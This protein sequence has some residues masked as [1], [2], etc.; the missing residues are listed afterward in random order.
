[1]S[2]PAAS[3]IFLPACD[4][5]RMLRDRQISATELL[6]LHL[7]RVRAVNPKINAIVALDEEHARADAKRAD[8]MATRGR[9]LGPL[10]GLP[11][12]VKDVFE[13]AG[14]PTTCGIPALRN[15]MAESDA[16]VVARLREHGA[17]IFGKTNVPEGAGDHQS[18]NSIYGITRNPWNLERTAGG[19]SGGAAAAVASC[20][21]PL[22]VGSDVG[23]S[24]RCPAHFCGVYGLKPS[25]GIVSTFGHI[26]P[27]PGTY[28]EPPMAVAGPIARSAYDLELALDVLAA[29]NDLDRKGK[30]WQLPAAR[31]ERLAD[32]R[33]A[34]WA[35]TRHYPV[36]AEYLEAIHAFADDL[37]SLG[38]NIDEEARPPIDPE[39]SN[40]VYMT[41]LFAMWCSGAPEEMF[42]RYAAAGAGLPADDKSWPARIARATRTD[43][44]T[45]V[46][47]GEDREKL[48]RAWE[49][50]FRDF[51]VLI[52][53]VM[54][55]PA[56]P[57]DTAGVD[58]TEQMKR[59]VKMSQ[60]TLPY[61]DNL[62]WPGLITV[63]NL[64][65]TAIPMRRHVDGL[66]VGV[67][68]ASAY[69]EDRTTLRFA[70]LLEDELGGFVP[71]DDA[72]FAG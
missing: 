71:P 47:L 3:P 53:P 50:F 38:V 13:T 14:M 34:L 41:T 42:Q 31:R 17:I 7:G 11:M 63:A 33:V 48:R 61:L 57:H 64:P 56:F 6:D 43:L 65:S 62:I 46:R 32:F 60:G 68:V 52:C 5:T 67:Q 10:H 19:S 54:S 20:M 27:P 9:P 36:D 22:E 25:H 49:L 28:S 69:L 23:G 45:W 59:S 29:P 4:L 12:T 66:P 70:Q 58:H 37:R 21:S 1:M 26:P 15:H 16:A 51:D 44:R 8:E 24:I 39:H 35:D 18:Y 40:D 55:T 30:V 72:R 2:P